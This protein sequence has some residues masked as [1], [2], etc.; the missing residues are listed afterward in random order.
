M[1]VFKFRAIVLLGLTEQEHN[2]THIPVAFLSKMDTDP[3]SH[4]LSFKVFD[5]STDTPCAWA[6]IC[7]TALPLRI[8]DSVF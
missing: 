6:I 4:D 8:L 1:P 2:A 3:G 7:F 5:D